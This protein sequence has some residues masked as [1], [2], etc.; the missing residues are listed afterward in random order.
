MYADKRLSVSLL[1]SLS[2]LL[3]LTVAHN[4]AHELSHLTI[5]LLFRLYSY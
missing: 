1:F 3:Y 2:L 5:A 4:Q